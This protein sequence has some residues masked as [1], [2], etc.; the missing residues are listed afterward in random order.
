MVSCILKLFIK[1]KSPLTFRAGD[2]G[3]SYG[4]KGHVLAT[5]VNGRWGNHS[6]Q[7][8]WLLDPT[9]GD[10]ATPIEGIFEGFPHFGYEEILTIDLR[11]VDFDSHDEA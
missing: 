9:T 6:F 2:L 3:W 11:K 4:K 7:R 8:Q 10:P 1:R 5:T